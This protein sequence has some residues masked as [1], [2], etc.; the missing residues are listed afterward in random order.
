M[1]VVGN[2]PV[3]RLIPRSSKWGIPQTVQLDRLVDIVV[4]ASASIAED[5]GVRIPLA[6]GFI[7]GWSH[8]SDLE[9]GTPVASL[10]GAWSY[11]VG[12]GNGWSGVSK[13]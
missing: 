11:R 13:L 6:P 4:E 5:P 8:T 2:P 12:A 3:K 9:I 10:P 7:R 1:V